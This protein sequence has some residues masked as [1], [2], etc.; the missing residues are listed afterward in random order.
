MIRF[1][2]PSLMNSDIQKALYQL[3]RTENIL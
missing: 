3:P 1:S 2:G